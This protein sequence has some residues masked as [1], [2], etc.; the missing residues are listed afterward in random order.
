M[1]LDKRSVG[2][3]NAADVGHDMFGGAIKTPLSLCE[4]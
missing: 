2:I 4:G 3:M 1:V